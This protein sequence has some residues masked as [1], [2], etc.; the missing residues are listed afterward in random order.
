MCCQPPPL[1]LQGP[2]ASWWGGLGGLTSL[3]AVAAE[4]RTW[5]TVPMTEPLSCTHSRSGS[6]RVKHGVCEC[7]CVCVCV[8][9]TSQMAVIPRSAKLPAALRQP[10]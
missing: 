4:G 1:M 7:V 3:G 6:G 9:E 8:C 5:Y 10:Q 2:P